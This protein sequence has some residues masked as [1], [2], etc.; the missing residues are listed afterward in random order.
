MVDIYQENSQNRS[1]GGVLGHITLEKAKEY[2]RGHHAKTDFLLESHIFKYGR[3]S[4]FKSLLYLPKV[5][6]K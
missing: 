6:L 4:I 3:T 1:V 5:S 2:L